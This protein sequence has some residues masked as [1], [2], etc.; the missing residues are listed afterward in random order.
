MYHLPTLMRFCNQHLATI[1]MCAMWCTQSQNYLYH[2]VTS[3][4]L[5]K[6][7]HQLVLGVKFR[8]HVNDAHTLSADVHESE[9]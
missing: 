5:G 3:S 2:P 7:Y 8:T 1:I 9:P 4:V 6:S